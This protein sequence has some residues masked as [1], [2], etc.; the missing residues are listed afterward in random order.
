[1]H[2][3]VNNRLVAVTPALAGKFAGPESELTPTERVQR[4]W[5]RFNEGELISIKGVM[6]YVHEI[7]ESRM[8]LK[9][10]K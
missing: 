7:G 8:V 3:P 4:D 9:L 1:M 2:D 6:F 5:T 10:K